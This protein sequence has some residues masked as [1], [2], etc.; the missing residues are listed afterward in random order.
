MRID[1]VGSGAMGSLFGGLLAEAGNEVCLIDVW[2]EH[3]EAISS[4]GLW[5]EGLTGDRFIEVEATTEPGKI[6]GTSNLL[7]FFVKSYHTERAARNV[8]LLVGEDTTILTLQN[9]LGNVEILS[10]IFGKEK[11]VAG[12]TSYGANV[13]GPGRVSHAG[14]GP[15]VI[16]ELDG[17][18]TDRIQE[19]ARLL[20]RAG[21]KT[22]TSSNVVGLIWSKLL[23]NVGINA[24][25][26]LINVRNGELIR[27]K[28]SAALQKELVAEAMEVAAGKGIALIHEDMAG[29]V[30][31][32]CEKTSGNINSMLQDVRNKRKTE[33][34]FI[35][36]AIVREGESLNIPTPA[37]RVVT[38]LM[39][40]LEESYEHQV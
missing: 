20:T 36:G 31:E 10:N 14:I 22:D 8:S 2:E 19:L 11:I 3:V 16:G 12:T 15:T 29:E 34:D 28:H 39:K 26:T 27:G 37:N 24:L 13:L 1:I 35:N 18:V 7:I 5:I 23:I 21:I 32:I 17:E 30:A 4:K 9:G 33:I 38:S 40:A 25:A 6:A